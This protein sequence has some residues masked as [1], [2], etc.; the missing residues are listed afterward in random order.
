MTVFRVHYP[1]TPAEAGQALVAYARERGLTDRVAALPG[2]TLRH[3]ATDDK[4]P[5]CGRSRLRHCGLKNGRSSP[6]IPPKSR[7]HSG[8]HCLTA[9]GLAGLS[10]AIAPLFRSDLA[11]LSAIFASCDMAEH[12]LAELSLRSGRF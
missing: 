1:G 2:E 9:P 12:R 6:P 5:F 3:W 7:T 4:A 8:P 10:A 11:C